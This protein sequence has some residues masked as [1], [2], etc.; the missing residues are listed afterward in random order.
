MASST[1]MSATALAAALGS[2]PSQPL[3]R[4]GE[5]PHMEGSFDKAPAE[6]LDTEDANGK[7]LTIANPEYESW[8]ARDQQVLRWLLNALSPDVLAHVIGLE[9]SAEVWASLNSHVAA[10]SKTR[11][12]Q[13]RSALNDTRKSDLSADKYFAKMKSIASELA[14]AGN[15]KA[16]ILGLS[17]RLTLLAGILVPAKMIV[18]LAMMIVLAKMT[19]AA[20]ID[21]AK[22]S[23]GTEMTALGVMMMSAPGAMMMSV[24]GAMIM[25]GVV[26]VVGSVTAGLPTM[27]TPLVRFAPFMDILPV[28]AGGAMEMIVMATVD[29]KG[30]ILPPMVLIQIGTMILGLL[31][32][33]LES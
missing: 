8:I 13:L 24:P 33:S 1:T 32:T 7:K 9:T 26:M 25:I 14:A 21:L 3:T 28:T 19:V 17:L 6:T 18:V 27:W 11:I 5:C 16:R 31:I 22:I 4:A 29:K 12:Q 2:S 23:A 10:K 30:P 20:T 15:T